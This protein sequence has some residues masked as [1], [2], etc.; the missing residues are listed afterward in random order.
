M[1]DSSVPDRLRLEARGEARSTLRLSQDAELP[2]YPA[3]GVL[4]SLTVV[5]LVDVPADGDTAGAA[6]RGWVRMARMLG[7]APPGLDAIKAYLHGLGYTTVST[8]VTRA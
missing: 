3:R 1:S 4:L 8:K 6:L 2:G 5:E 7:A